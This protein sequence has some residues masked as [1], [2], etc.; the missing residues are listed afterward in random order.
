MASRLSGFCFSLRGYSAGEFDQYADAMGR[1]SLHLNGASTLNG[2]HFSQY[3]SNAFYPP[4]YDA[5]TVVSFLTLGTSLF[6]AR[7]VSAVFSVFSLFAVFE[8]A[9]SMY[10]GKNSVARST[11]FGDYARLLLA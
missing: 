4:L 6:A 9:Y 1:S 10:N 8:L 7:L 3:V 2:G 11:T 5:A